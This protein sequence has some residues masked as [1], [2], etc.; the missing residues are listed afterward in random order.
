MDLDTA[1]EMATSNIRVGVDT[2]LE[3]GMD[4]TDMGVERVLVVT[5]PHLAQ[6]SPVHRLLEA[7]ER[8]DV[9]FHL[10]DR[11]RVEP[12]DHSFKEAIEV[13]VDGGFDGFVA[14]GG[15]STIDTAKPPTFTPPI[16]QIF[17]T[18]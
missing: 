16:Q 15:G 12:T 7:L 1:F 2:T 18:T 3:V 10:Y 13:A 5:D 14:I 9:S 17:S 8:E 6:L 11:V 4:L